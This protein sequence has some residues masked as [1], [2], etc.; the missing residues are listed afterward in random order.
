MAI[1]KKLNSNVGIDVSYHRV[2]GVNINY[3]EKR[4]N[5][6]LASYINANKRVQKYKPLEVVDIEV[7]KVDFDIFVE[8]DPRK[9]A[10]KWLKVNVEGFDEARDDLG[11]RED[12]A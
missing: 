5:I 9:A 4:V 8:C 1:I 2:I 11:K 3:H 7:P 6:T 10:Y 12:E